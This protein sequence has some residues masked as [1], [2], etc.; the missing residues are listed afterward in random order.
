MK[1]QANQNEQ[2]LKV[3]LRAAE[4]YQPRVRNLENDLANKDQLYKVTLKGKDDEIRNLS[5]ANDQLAAQLK[6]AKA[7]RDEALKNQKAE[8]NALHKQALSPYEQRIRQLEDQIAN[9]RATFAKQLD[10][11]GRKEHLLDQK[12]NE[13]Y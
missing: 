1:E 3:K 12:N 6:N 7:E 5:A 11:I 10:V 4:E 9:E 13:I 2:A 8:L